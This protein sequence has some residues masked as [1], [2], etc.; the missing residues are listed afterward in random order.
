MGGSV[1]ATYF[2]KDPRLHLEPPEMEKLSSSNTPRV[3]TKLLGASTIIRNTLTSV[4]LW[5]Q[6][7]RENQSS[8]MCFE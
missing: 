2:S 5:P 1:K 7:D 3:V 8:A 6:F 4:I